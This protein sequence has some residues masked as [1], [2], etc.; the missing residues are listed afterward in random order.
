MHAANKQYVA[1]KQHPISIRTEL[2]FYDYQ[3]PLIINHA[4]SHFSSG[5]STPSIFF[6]FE[7]TLKEVTSTGLIPSTTL[8]LPAWAVIKLYT[9]V[10]RLA[11]GRE[12]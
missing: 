2:Q 4:E 7:R 10:K 6:N 3:K 5:V 9:S 11:S 8:A 12:A 1:N